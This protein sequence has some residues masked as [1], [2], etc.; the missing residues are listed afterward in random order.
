MKNVLS[1]YCFLWVPPVAFAL[2]AIPM[3]ASTIG[4]SYTGGS[5]TFTAT[6]A[7]VYDILAYGAQGGTGA[8]N[9][10]GGLGAEIGGDFTLSA[11]ETLTID[12]GGTNPYA[13]PQVGGGGGGTFVVDS[14]GNPL[15]VAGGGGGGVYDRSGTNASTTT[16]GTAGNSGGA[17]GASGSGGSGGGDFGG[18]GGA[19]FSGGDGGYSGAAG[20]YQG[21]DYSQGL[22]GGAGYTYAHGYSGSGGYG[23]GGGGG[24]LG[25]GGGGGYSGGGGGDDE[26]GAGGGGGS[27]LAADCLAGVTSDCLADGNETIAT[28][29][30]YPDSSDNG[31][32]EIT[33]MS[34]IAPTPEPP[35][36]TLLAL[37][38]LGIAVALK[39]RGTA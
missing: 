12:V 26:N 35:S 33:Q 10:S 31:Y 13:A 30:A 37:G 18:G 7:G 15:V 11:N 4:Y 27:F 2:A 25:A 28:D 36:L 9:N 39:L 38:L 14:E 17:G 5:Q 1:R 24:A 23:G 6:T 16:S 32:V 21:S 19:G 8:N 29:A 3:R 34:S 22:A 20:G